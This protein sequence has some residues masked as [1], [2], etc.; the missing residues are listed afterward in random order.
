MT[1]QR[2]IRLMR[3]QRVSLSLLPFADAAGGALPLPR[4]LRLSL[5]QMTVGM[6]AV[7]LTGTINRVMIVELGLSAALVA[8]M[9]SLPLIAAPFRAL[10]GH[11][12]DR[13]Q[14][15]LGWRRVPFIWFGS[16]LQFGGF[17]IMPFAL[18][19]LSGDTHGPVW[20]GTAGA[21]FAFIL[22][23][24]GM[25]TTQTA[26][27][28]LA[29]DLATDEQRPHV[30][31]LLFVMLLAGMLLAALVFGALLSDFSQL[32]LIQV[33][34]A[35]AIITLAVNLVALW[36]Q[37]PR[38]PTRNRDAAARPPFR[39]AWRTVFQRPASRRVLLAV[40]VGTAGFAMQDILL[41]PYGAEVL[42][43]NV[44]ATTMLTGIFAFGM[45]SAFAVAG[46]WLKRGIDPHRLAAYGAL[47]GVVGFAMLAVVAGLVSVGLFRVGVVLIGFGSGLFGVGTL[48]AAMRLAG[49]DTSGLVVGAWG[50]VQAS[51][52]G[53]AIL[54]GGVLR[55]GIDALALA[56]YLG[57]TLNTSSTGYS[58]VYQLEILVLFV[59]L[60][61]IGP[62]AKHDADPMDSKAG[63]GLG[64]FPTNH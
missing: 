3:W 30:V 5:F 11:R 9:V 18:I 38:K 13:Y 21:A 2:A 35:A 1:D 14:S 37:E 58:A 31:A 40:G 29:S 62:L 20:I 44:G 42:G 7:L 17:A 27:L 48:I 45:L 43:L 22:V 10:I 15:F 16:L 41:E 64:E 12:S 49:D 34:Q 4:L 33:I 28:A 63:L 59:T 46:A 36:K 50:A 39:A 52:A 47:A 61:I 8:I 51:A 25:H 57:E 26:G 56:G 32:R 19:I 53:L 6:A 55:D 23:G 24:I 54:L 60:A